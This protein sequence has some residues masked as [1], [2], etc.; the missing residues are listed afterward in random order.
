MGVDVKAINCIH[1][2]DLMSYLKINIIG[3]IEI[4]L[5]IGCTNSEV[6]LE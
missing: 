1:F 2:I 6:E 4:I 3:L 5:N